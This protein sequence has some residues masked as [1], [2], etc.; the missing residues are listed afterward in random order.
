VDKLF[1]PNQGINSK[2]YAEKTLGYHP[3][4]F[5]TFDRHCPLLDKQC[6]LEVCGSWKN[7]EVYLSNPARMTK[8]QSI[9]DIEP[10]YCRNPLITG[11]INAKTKS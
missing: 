8:D 9:Y 1:E 6:L 2:K 11:E 10:G 5:N 3:I 7:A 4:K